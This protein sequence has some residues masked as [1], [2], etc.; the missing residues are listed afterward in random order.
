MPTATLLLR[1][2]NT[3]SLSAIVE[4]SQQKPLH[5]SL[6]Y[7]LKLRSSQL[8]LIPIQK[9]KS[10]SSPHSDEGFESDI[11]SLSIVSSDDNFPTRN[12]AQKNISAE[13]DSANGS[14]CSDTDEELKENQI[15]T[16]SYELVNCLCYSDVKFPDV[17]VFVLKI[18]ALVFK[19]GNLEDLESFYTN[20]NTLKAVSNQKTY[21]KKVGKFNLLQRIDDDGVTHIEIKKEPKI[22]FDL[23]DFSEEK[24]PKKPERRKKIKGKAPP[25]PP[26][27]TL[28]Q[29][30]INNL[31][32]IEDKEQN[33]L[34]GEYIRVNVPKID[35]ITEKLTQTTI[36][37]N[38]FNIYQRP[39]LTSYQQFKFIAEEKKILTPQKRFPENW[40]CSMPRN[41][42]KYRS[43][44]ETR[45]FQPQQP[46]NYNYRYIDAKNYCNSPIY[47]RKS[48]QQFQSGSIS[49][50][51]FGMTGKLKDFSNDFIGINDGNRWNSLGELTVRNRN[52]IDSNLKSVIKKEDAK[53]KE[54]KVTFSAYATVQVV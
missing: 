35:V 29:I 27:T 23:I 41:C 45:L 15:E 18:D 26:T 48:N 7:E 10:P 52:Q 3:T 39:K 1:E 25:P 34:K 8:D 37:N 20:F 53:K 32:G 43:K 21:G 44:S 24:V 50:R 4:K 51:F 13:T 11:D 22:D 28:N 16:E 54:K 46:I 36:N 42:S 17:L 33:V 31:N 9:I 47:L 14:A 30:K 2:P 40:T 49:N 19:F 12:V 38:H 6:E 5:P